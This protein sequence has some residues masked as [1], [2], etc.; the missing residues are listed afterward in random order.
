MFS[1]L[2]PNKSQR[3]GIDLTS[4]Q[5]SPMSVERS[6]LVA[7]SYRPQRS[8]QKN[9]QVE[10]TTAFVPHVQ[11]NAGVDM[12]VDP[13]GASP[14]RSKP[15]T[16]NQQKTLSLTK[17]SPINLKT[18]E[19]LKVRNLNSFMNVEEHL[20]GQRVKQEK[21]RIYAHHNNL[22]YGRSG[23][24][25]TQKVSPKNLIGQAQLMKNK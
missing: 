15:Q 22:G 4:L 23:V 21:V 9:A 13:S 1:S 7:T 5:P 8:N 6:S 3:V 14:L 25:Q 17:N 11:V 10:K 18:E 19:L 12:F 2:T 16:P 24:I 20:K